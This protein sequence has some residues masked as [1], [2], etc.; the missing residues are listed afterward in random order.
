MMRVSRLVAGV[1]IYAIWPVAA[2]TQLSYSGT[3][4]TG[5]LVLTRTVNALQAAQQAQVTF[6]VATV[7][8]EVLPRIPPRRLRPPF[9]GV[10]AFLAD[11]AQVQ[12]LPV[13]AASGVTGFEGLT[14]LDQR[15]A[16]NGNQLSVEPANPAIAVGNGYLLAGV[17]NAVQ[18]YTESGSPLLPVVLSSNQ[19]FGLPP[20]ITRGVTNIFGVFPTD[21]RVYFDNTI[22]RWFVL[23]Q[24]QDNDIFGN[25]LPSS[26]IYLAVSQ[27][28]DPTG[29]YNIYTMDTTDP[30]RFGCPCFADYP[31]IGSDANGLFISTNEFSTS[32]VTFFGT[33]I[34]AISKA[35]LTANSVT[36]TMVRF[37]LPFATGF[38]FAIQPATTPPG[39]SSFVANG[40]LEYFVSSNWGFR[41]NT[42]MAIWA[43][44]NTSSLGTATPLL[45]L[46]QTSVPSITYTL[47]DPAPQ[48]PG[49]LPYGSSLSP[50]GTL[51]F[52][53]VGDFRVQ[54]ASYSGG[55]LYAALSTAV[56]DESGH[57]RAAAGY[58][59][60]SPAFRS[61]V[62][63]A[64]LL[65]QGY[66]AAKNNYVIAPAVAVN[67]QG[68][69]VIA[70]TLVGPDYFP[71]A[72][73]IPFDTFTTG[74]SIQVARPGNAPEDGFT[75]YPGGFGPGI[76][77][78]GDYSAAVA[79]SNGS[80]LFVSEY[81][82][83]APR[84]QV[85]NWGTFI[86][87]YVP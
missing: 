42:S 69:G 18:V 17:N 32:S 49:P 46:L 59:V 12:T 77:R 25:P 54:S 7:A 39:A 43:M 65:R 5:Q 83:N 82:P 30:Q 50:P 11:P 28:A 34:H 35:S 70:F 61:G 1:A 51:A 15:Q 44:Y 86:A 24:A 20:A 48:K 67:P 53:D 66:V 14:H 78:W 85:A 16:N 26:H 79:A 19:L 41:T 56:T 74:S 10:Q 2:Q 33:Q 27:T 13:S 57:T 55:R 81:I 80:V 76:A 75:G 47:P 58:I 22:S 37:M 64:Q 9:L 72:A 4:V 45:T 60:V 84:T 87:R 36:P 68:R 71:S 62:L 6:S 29:T 31:Q 63:S 38:E 52:L 21:M 40:G 73:F 3:N 23:Q 8:P